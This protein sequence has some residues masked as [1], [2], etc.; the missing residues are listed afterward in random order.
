MGVC[1]G[2]FEDIPCG[3]SSNPADQLNPAIH[4]GQVEQVFPIRGPGSE[5]RIIVSILP[6]EITADN[7]ECGSDII[8]E[9]RACPPRREEKNDREEE[10]RIRSQHFVFWS[11]KSGDR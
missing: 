2:A 4:E 10:K 7:I 8:Q 11:G 1:K 9:R 5:D 6:D 3:R